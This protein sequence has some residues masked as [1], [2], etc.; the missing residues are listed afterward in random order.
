M[1]TYN[2]YL[3]RLENIALNDKQQTQVQTLTKGFFDRVINSARTLR[4]RFDEGARVRWTT[5]CPTS[6]IRSHELLVYIVQSVSS[7]V[8]SNHYPNVTPGTNGVTAWTTGAGGT[9]GSEVYVG[10]MNPALTARVIFHE[11]MHNKTH[12]ND[13]RLHSRGGLAS[14]TVM[15]NTRLTDR[16]I[17]DM[18]RVL[19]NN[20]PQWTGG[21][22]LFNDPLRG[23]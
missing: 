1:A 12:W 16:N 23:L 17:Q 22:V 6:R 9:T 11:T 8:V 4:S 10:R 5:S 14:A 3:A 21:C 13:L 2:I 7:S 20:R 18:A 15:E 19:G